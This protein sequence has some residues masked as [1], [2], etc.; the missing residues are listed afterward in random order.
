MPL[1]HWT[2]TI[3]ASGGPVRLSSVLADAKALQQ[4]G[5]DDISYG[6]VTFELQSGTAVFIGDENV[7]STNY[8]A[9]VTTSK[10][11]ELYGGAVRLGD[12]WAVG[13][14]GDKLQIGAVPL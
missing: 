14:S 3:P 7:S 1:R 4:G 11:Y 5:T 6:L 10:T 12:L 8:A 9:K 2:L 13:T